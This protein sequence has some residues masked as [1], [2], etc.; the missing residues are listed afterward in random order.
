MKASIEMLGIPDYV[1]SEALMG[2]TIIGWSLSPSGLN[3]P[4][5]VQ[6]KINWPDRSEDNELWILEILDIF[7]AM[8][9]HDVLFLLSVLGRCKWL[10]WSFAL[11]DVLYVLWPI[12]WWTGWCRGHLQGVFGTILSGVAHGMSC[13]FL[14]NLIGESPASTTHYCVSLTY[15]LL[16]RYIVSGDVHQC[17][18]NKFLFT[19]YATH[20]FGCDT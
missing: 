14:C 13:A 8:C 16:L 12:L 3:L 10:C 2:L 7:F 1:T 4:R 11:S 15:F 6:L 19:I 18:P 20:Q 9:S 5:Q 17:A